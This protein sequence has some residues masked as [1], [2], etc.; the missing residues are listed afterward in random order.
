MPAKEVTWPTIIW[1][2]AEGGSHLG[3]LVLTDEPVAKAGGATL[4]EEDQ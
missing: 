2:L 3:C 1:A 4:Q